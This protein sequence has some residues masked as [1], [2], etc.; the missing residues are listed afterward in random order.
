MSRLGVTA[1][2]MPERLPD[3]VEG[4]H[5]HTLCEQNSDSLARTLDAVISRFGCYLDGSS[6]GSVKWINLWRRSSYHAP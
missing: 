6:G 3:Y 4:I 2:N 1:E 5:F